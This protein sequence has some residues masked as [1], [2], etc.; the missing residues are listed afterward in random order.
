[1]IAWMKSD[2]CLGAEW[3][4]RIAAFERMSSERALYVVSTD[5]ISLQILAL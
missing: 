2:A 1:M 4:M 5:F 3:D